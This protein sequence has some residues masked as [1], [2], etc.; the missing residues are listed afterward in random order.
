M[1]QGVKVKPL[2][3]ICDERGM[4]MKMQESTDEEFVGF[5]EMYFSAVYPGVVKGWHLH[6]K[7]TLNYTVIKGMIKLV[8]YD[9]REGS[10]TRFELQELCIGED[11]YC[12]VQIPP[13]VW[14]GFKG[15]G[16]EMA[17][18]ADLTNLTHDPDDM[19]RLDPMKNDVIAYDWAL[20]NR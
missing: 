14:N 9:D 2:K 13:N 15:I 19:V 5:G 7:T 16:A 12:L 3:K 11:N 20:K 1:I 17:I 18:V 4:I 10:P 6:K 8:L